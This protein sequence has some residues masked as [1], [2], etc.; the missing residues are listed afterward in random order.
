M[1]A[2]K[3]WLGLLV[4]L[5]LPQAA[6]ADAHGGM[7]GFSASA[8]A[9]QSAL[10]AQFDARID[11]AQ[12]SAW[13]QTLSRHP[14]HPGSVYARQNAEYLAE[15]FRA[16]G[17][18]ADIVSYEILLPTPRTRELEMLAPQP[19][20]ASLREDPVAGDA[21]TQQRDELLPPY[22]AFSKD[23][24][25]EAEL[26][27]V[28]YGVPED[29]E[30]LARYGIDVEGKIVIARYGK[31]WRGIKP[32]LAAEHGAVGTLIYSDPA[33]DGYAQ[34]DVYP[35]GPFK[36]ASG[37]Q[38]GSVMDM[39]LYPG[40]V[41]TP[42][43][44]ATARARRIPLDEVEVITKVPVLPISYRDAQPLLAALDGEVVPPEWRG[45]LPITYHFGP[46]PARVR[47]KVAFDW[48]R[49][50]IYNVIARLT[51]SKY[52]EQ[53]VVRGNHHDA[54]N[55]GAADPVSGLTALLAE[56]R[57]VGE[58][59]RTGELPLRT[60]VYAAWDAE[61]P[62]LIGSTEWV[63]DNAQLLH[64]RA[65]AYINTDGNSRGFLLTGGSHTLEPFFDQVADSVTDPQ[66]GASLQAR[67]AARVR[68]AGTDEQRAELKARGALRLSPLGS[69]S[70]YTP[71]LQH[72]GIASAN[73][74]FR[75]EG[76]SGSYHTLYDTYE[77]YATFRD[78]GF[79]Y[80]GALAQT[81]G[82][83]VLRLANA[84]VLPFRFAA[85]VDNLHHYL[86]QIEKLAEKKR[87]EA[88]EVNQNLADGVYALALDPQKQLG[89]PQP[90]RAVPHFNLAPLK[91]VID[92]LQSASQALDQALE[93]LSSAPGQDLG[94]INQLLYQSERQLTSRDGLPGRPW[95]RHQ[96]YAPGFYTGYG[97]K[98]LPRVREAIEA[99]Q[100]DSVDG[101]IAHTADVLSRFA[102][103]LERI[104]QDIQAL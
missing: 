57:A 77:H 20:V 11:P 86:E 41:Q 93:A 46:G 51:G 94:S 98:T 17:F 73:L 39:P 62:G 29:Y 100:Y 82:R 35:I 92:D 79:L 61:E 81:A 40:D 85:L 25:V 60:I 43:R 96:V 58:L 32:K 48:Q 12:I 5:I 80:G 9:R 97:V 42:G 26:V 4:C 53:W 76:P 7:L 65:V 30:T 70:D 84:E 56:A 37:V 1:S 28:N 54:W 68:V 24:D 63:E 52:P 45:A 27:F 78:P 83:A 23:G 47:L 49:V 14:H 21:S 87:Q 71:F 6:M 102:T 59:A 99:E 2:F 8:A 75:G 91:N 50:E 44:A 38:R 101:N 13:T 74:T 36:H 89:P 69:G 18:A 34:G 95:Y 66:T 64:E 3:S 104:T 15:Q 88:Q 67:R 19:F 31:S 33:D 22:N 55:H 10:E 103:Y 16:W 90:E 72:L